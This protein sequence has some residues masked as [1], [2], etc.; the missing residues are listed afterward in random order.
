MPAAHAIR[1]RFERDERVWQVPG[2]WS[3]LPFVAPVVGAGVVGLTVFHS[4]IYHAL[5][6]EDSVFKWLE[7]GAYAVAAALGGCAAV[8]V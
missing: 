4:G 8:R 2:R 7:F 3:R 1:R 6:R 5:V